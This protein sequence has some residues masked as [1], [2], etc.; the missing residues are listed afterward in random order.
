MDHT[1][2]HMKKNGIPLTRENYLDFAYLG[3]PPP[4]E[5]WGAEL[6]AELPEELRIGWPELWWEIE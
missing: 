3:T 4:P 5:E 2:E 1:L 6:E